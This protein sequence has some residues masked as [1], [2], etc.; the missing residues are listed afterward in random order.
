MSG[1]RR[2]HLGD[3]LD[4]L[5]ADV[6]PLSLAP[7]EQVRRRGEQRG[8]RR[9]T[10]LA[11]G[12][13][14]AVAAI[15]LGATQLGRPSAAPS[16]PSGGS[17]AGPTAASGTPT[18]SPSPATS[19]GPSS[20][21]T[22]IRHLVVRLRPAAPGGGHVAAAYFLPGPLWQGPDLN[23][24]H[25]MRSVEPRE[26]EGSVTRFACDPDTDVHGAVAFLQ[27]QDAVTQNVT[28]TQKVR[29]LP[30]A[31]AATAFA[32]RMARTMA[33]CQQRLRQ[34]ALRDAGP[35]SPGETA[36]TPNATVVDVPQGDVADTTGAVRLFTTTTDYGTGASSAIV[37]WVVIA[38][39]G[40]AVTF[41]SLP[42]LEGSSVSVAALSRIADEARQQLR[43]A[44][45][46]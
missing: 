23:Q 20:A 24:G 3:A 4:T 31:A 37:D 22:P 33:T 35:L 12:G 15:A 44:A 32:D 36:P 43:W 8:R 29:L 2:D 27:V 6:E 46:R 34:Q 10:L 40:R 30:S 18:G 21:S 19:T 5:R 9:R 39:E 38:R 25:A 7:A 14:A 26:S 1:D 42:S 41:L 11:T 13:V 45:S 16:A 28:A 17:T